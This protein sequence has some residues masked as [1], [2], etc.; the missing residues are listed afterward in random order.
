MS[1]SWVQ[2]D[3]RVA[4]PAV[5]F[6]RNSPPA[7]RSVRFARSG[8]IGAMNSGFGSPGVASVQSRPPLV[9]TAGDSEVYSVITWSAF[10][11]STIVSPPSPPN[12]WLASNGWNR[13]EPVISFEVP[14][15]CRPPQN[16]VL[17]DI[18]S[19]PESA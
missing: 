16:T 5:D 1:A 17:P 13:S 15:S 10:A 9:V 8:E 3:G 6:H 7:Y 14:L 18:G 11:W 12:G 4:K 19:L 2:L